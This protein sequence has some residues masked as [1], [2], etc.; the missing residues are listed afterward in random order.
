MNASK[1]DVMHEIKASLVME[2]LSDS[3]GT[4][5]PKSVVHAGARLE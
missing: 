1:T 3:D 5:L 4:P 2:S